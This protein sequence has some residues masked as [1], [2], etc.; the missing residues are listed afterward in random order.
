MKKITASLLFFLCVAASAAPP[1]RAD[2]AKDISK[3]PA[4]SFCI[5]ANLETAWEETAHVLQRMGLS[6][7]LAD[8][9]HYVTA[10]EFALA[11][12]A[13]LFKIAANP[14]PLLKG[15]F[16]MKISLFQE[17]ESY[18]RMS[19]VLQIRQNKAIGK[20]ERLLKTRG[21]FEKYFA[22]QVN[23]LAI[24]RQYPKL[25]EIRLGMDLIPDLESERYLVARVEEESPAGEAGFRSGDE[26]I[27]IDGRPVSI[28]GELFEILLPE[29]SA[30]QFRFRVR[31]EKKEMEIA[32]WVIRV[33]G[34]EKSLGM[35]AGRSSGTGEEFK[36]VQ[37]TADSPADK[38]GIHL[39]DVIVRAGGRAVLSWTDYYRALA[40]AEKELSLVL[41][42]P[43]R[44]E[45]ER[46]LPLSGGEL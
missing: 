19:V 22:Y 34:K 44:G 8:S 46:V 1:A 10:T 2:L 20:G 45:F 30:R 41:L 21:V 13:K 28:R 12:Y 4:K 3:L 42:R 40:S 25:Y 9:S 14:R 27:S 31:R 43:G 18:T 37:L 5:N 35:S 26:L 11:D 39:G 24:S 36:I 32:A 16:T 15:R 6:P 23:Q 17:T 29:E 38:A 33:S 7:S